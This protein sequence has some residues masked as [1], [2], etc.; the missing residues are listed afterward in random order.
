M[1]A[2][3]P[4][5]SPRGFT[6]LE[7][8]ISMAIFTVLGTMV[9]YFMR[10]SLNVFSVGTRESARLD[11]QD[12][13]L[14]QVRTD[15]GGLIVP[16]QFDTPPPRPSEDELQRSGRAVPPAPPAVGIRLRS[17][18]VQLAQVADEN[19]KQVP[20]PYLA[21]VVADASEW[22]NKLKR[23]AGEVPTAGGSQR[24]LTP[25]T[26]LE[27]DRDTRYLPTGGL[28]EVVWIAV[29]SDVMRGP[30]E[31]GPSYPAV[32]T[33]Y[34]GFRTPIGD[35][36]KSLL[37]PANFDTPDEIRKACRPVAEGLLHFGA[38]WRRVFATDWEAGLGV[39]LGETSP[40]VGPVW[41]S[42]RGVDKDWVFFK[43]KESLADP[44]DDMFPRFVRLEATLVDATQFG[45]GRGEFRL[46]DPLAADAVKILVTDT[47]P[48]LQPNLGKERWLKVGTEWMGYDVRDVDWEK[49]E[50]RVRR[51]QRGTKAL[52]HPVDAWGYVGQPSTLEIEMPVFR[53]RF[54]REKE[55][56]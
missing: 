1:S 53:D 14:P 43:G 41:D 7:I 29:P 40:Y 16:D 6:L 32:M 42:S 11:R 15:L 46:T 12:T 3:G 44:S 48:L 47:D 22:S 38:L 56:R 2:H 9:V 17:G 36:E 27:G 8:M 51:G 55:G 31:G 10:Q 20:C 4:R 13:L 50:V 45:P 18:F 35:P 5:R 34:R 37:D 39:G 33:L 24:A 52:S 23:R 21:F 49:K 30:G 26:V 25:T 28:M 54:V 19:F